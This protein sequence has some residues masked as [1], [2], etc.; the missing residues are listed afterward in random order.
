MQPGK[1]LD[2]RGWESRLLRQVRRDLAADLPGTP[3]P[4]IRMLIDRAAWLTLRLAQ[5]D[6]AMVGGQ[7]GDVPAYVA[8]NGALAAVLERISRQRP[9]RHVPRPAHQDRPV[10]AA[11]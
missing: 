9:S 7:A 1:P 5:Y 4:S 11:A 3:S 10:E 8:L 2:G 6:Q